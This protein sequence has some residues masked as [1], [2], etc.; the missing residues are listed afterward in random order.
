MGR[1]GGATPGKRLM[2]MVVV[3]CDNI[4]DLG[5]GRVVVVPAGDIGFIK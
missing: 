4:I 1:P 3:S 5:N 2:G